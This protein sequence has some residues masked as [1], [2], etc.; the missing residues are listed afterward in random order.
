M[1]CKVNS[2]ARCKWNYVLVYAFVVASLLQCGARLCLLRA[3][4]HKKRLDFG[5]DTVYIRDVDHLTLCAG[6][7][8]RWELAMNAE[9]RAE[10]KARSLREHGTLNA[11]VGA[12]RDELFGA[13][14]FFD[15]ADLLQVKYEML[16]SV[17]VEGRSI[18]DASR[19]FGFSRP[20]FYQMKARF[21]QDGFAGL[22][23]KKRG[24]KGPRK[25]RDEVLEFLEQAVGRDDSL[26]GSQL[27]QMVEER[28]RFTIHPRTIERALQRRRKRGRRS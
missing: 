24:P 11:R 12:V 6:P 14:D 9:T 8:I 18:R 5:S 23:P 28:Y 4:C 2:A 19:S 20:S 13:H 25:L 21:E 3:M 26:D 1:P 10:Q 17:Q 22:L 7:N 16:R 15:P 27:R